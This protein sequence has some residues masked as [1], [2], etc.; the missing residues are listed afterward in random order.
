MQG[1]QRVSK[2][3]LRV[4]K[5]RLVLWDS[6]FIMDFGLMTA[7]ESRD[8]FSFRLFTA[9]TCDGHFVQLQVCLVMH[10]R[11]CFSL[12]T[13]TGEAVKKLFNLMQSNTS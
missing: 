6:H 4:Q 12:K 5:R 7:G 8:I 11:N 3:R 13:D 9:V 1:S 10:Y 2:T